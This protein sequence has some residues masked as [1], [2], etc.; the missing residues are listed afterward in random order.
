MVKEIVA[1]IT[2]RGQVTIPAEVRKVLGVAPRGKVAFRI[3]G[4]S[5]SLAPAAFDVE[6]LAG[7]VQPIRRPE[8]FEELSRVAKEE[9]V[10]KVVRELRAE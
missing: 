1:S 10:E 7:S 8:D 4:A 5:V 3:D 9:H 6:T 2:Q